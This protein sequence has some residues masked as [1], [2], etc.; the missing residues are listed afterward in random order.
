[1]TN[2]GRFKVDTEKEFIKSSHYYFDT[3]DY[4]KEC[5]LAEIQMEIDFEKHVL[6]RKERE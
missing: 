3:R 6:T 2:I 5:S 1:M 4:A